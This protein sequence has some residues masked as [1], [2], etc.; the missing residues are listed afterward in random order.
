MSSGLHMNVLFY[1]HSMKK[2]PKERPAPEDLMVS[3]TSEPLSIFIHVCRSVSVLLCT[4]LHLQ[5]QI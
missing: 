4:F 2:Q 3:E 5:I 1:T